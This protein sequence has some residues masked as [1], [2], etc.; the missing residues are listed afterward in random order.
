MIDYTDLDQLAIEFEK[1]RVFGDPR[2]FDIFE[3][4][5]DDNGLNCV[6]S[7][8]SPY[9]YPELVNDP[10]NKRI[11][12][13]QAIREA[14]REF[15][16]FK[17][18]HAPE[19]T[20]YERIDKNK[21]TFHDV[22]NSVLVSM[23]SYQKMLE[24]RK[25]EYFGTKD[26]YKENPVL[27]TLLKLST[28]KSNFIKKMNEGKLSRAKTVKKVTLLQ[29]QITEIEGK[30]IKD[31]IE[32]NIGKIQYTIT[33]NEIPQIPIKLHIVPPDDD[34]PYGTLVTSGM[35]TY[36]MMAPSMAEPTDAELFMLLSPDWLLP[37]KIDKNSEFYW[38]IENLLFLVKYVHRNRQWFSLGHTFGNEH[39]PKPFAHNTNLCAFLFKFPYKVLPPT[40][41]E[42]MI[43]R[44]PVYFLQI[45][46]IYR[47]EMDF[48]MGS[49]P[50]EFAAMYKDAGLPEYT[51][52]KRDNLCIGGEF[53]KEGKSTFCKNC[54]TVIRDL[55]M[56]E[57]K[58]TC[59][60]CGE[61]IT[62]D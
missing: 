51:E 48:L 54:G 53:E 5:Q 32:T 61:I 8:F 31:H 17:V 11:L 36:P 46:P 22:S 23:Q 13:V 49:D 15:I 55:D 27:A 26:M 18:S 37:P 43:G 39:P 12:N 7:D 19:G 60:Q 58:I 25:A 3:G 9:T 44:K 10:E 33:D 20:I 4:T 21:H 45:M 40:F 24:G 59:R 35:S 16:R 29:E 14:F 2:D 38:P 50:E 42:L 34:R 62:L 41:C 47:E 30:C 28:E 56:T 6:V 52:L 57:K 1:R